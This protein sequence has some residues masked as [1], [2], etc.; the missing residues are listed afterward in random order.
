MGITETGKV[1]TPGEE[2]FENAGNFLIEREFDIRQENS[3]APSAPASVSSRVEL[4][5][6]AGDAEGAENFCSS[7]FQGIPNSEDST[8]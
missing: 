4:W 2:V 3:S 7:F 1:E 5:V 6:T 8:E